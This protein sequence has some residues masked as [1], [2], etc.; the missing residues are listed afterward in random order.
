[1]IKIIFTNVLH[2]IEKKHNIAPRFECHTSN[3]EH[4]SIAQLV[5]APDC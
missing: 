3:Y 2:I 5:R 4:S 1:M